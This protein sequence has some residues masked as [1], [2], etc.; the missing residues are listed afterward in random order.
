MALS[1]VEGIEEVG[2]TSAHG[3]EALYDFVF[4]LE[5]GA[6]ATEVFA[7][8]VECEAFV[9]DEEADDAELLDVVRGVHAGASS[10]AAGT[11]L[12]ELFLPETDC[13]LGQVKNLRNI[14]NPIEFFCEF[15]VVGVHSQSITCP[16]FSARRMISS[17]CSGEIS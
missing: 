7:C 4:A 12:G 9:F 10:V 15:F 16:A 8:A 5:V 3:L 11:Q 1:L 13:G 17:Y 6:V 2:E 14:A